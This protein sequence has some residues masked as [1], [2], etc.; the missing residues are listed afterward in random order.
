MPTS[1]KISISKEPRGSKNSHHLPLQNPSNNKTITIARSA[2]GS[3]GRIQ[4]A[5]WLRQT[6]SGS[7]VQVATWVH[8]N[9]TVTRP[10]IS[11]ITWL[12]IW[13]QRQ[14]CDPRVNQMLYLKCDFIIWFISLLLSRDNYNIASAFNQENLSA[15]NCVQDSEFQD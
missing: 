15:I 4:I 6:P 12:P 11:I 1:R 8:N 3:L 10:L 5:K 13:C 9:N 14:T 2:H 7:E